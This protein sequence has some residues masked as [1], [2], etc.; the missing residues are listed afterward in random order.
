VNSSWS[1][2]EDVGC[3]GVLARTTPTT[4]TTES[5]FDNIYLLQ[6]GPAP[7][8]LAALLSGQCRSRSR[9]GGARCARRSP[10]KG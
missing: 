5:H 2:L 3:V 8:A 10:G 7:L 1:A 4:L 9:R 6:V